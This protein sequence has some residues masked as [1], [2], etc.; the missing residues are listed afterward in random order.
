[1]DTLDRQATAPNLRNQN[2]KSR[3]VFQIKDCA[4]T[5][6]MR[7]LSKLFME[8]D[9]SFFE[10]AEKAVNN[11][12]QN[13]FFESMREIR[14]KKDSIISRFSTEFNA[15]CD[16]FDGQQ[17]G[18]S[19]PEA[20]RSIE[21]LAL[22]QT[23]ELERNVTINNMVNNARIEC[24]EQ[25]Y[26]LNK[27][28]DLLIPSVSV[29]EQ[30]NPLDPAQICSAF[31][32]ASDILD[33]KIKGR[34]V[35]FKQFERMVM[36]D[37]QTL[38]TTANQQLINAGILPQVQ[39]TAYKNQSRS[40]PQQAVPR[41]HEVTTTAPSGKL[42][43]FTQ[44]FAELSQLLSSVRDL[45]ISGQ[46]G[47]PLFVSQNTGP[48]LDSTELSDLLS[49]L[50]QRHPNGD[51][52]VS[53]LQPQLDLR[54]LL[55]EVLNKRQEK[56]QKAKVGKSDEDVINLIA[57][58]FD[59]VLDDKQ[60]PIRIQALVSRLQIPVLKVSLKDR[61]FFSTADHP[62]R[63]LIN[64]I[65]AV[66]IGMSDK[67]SDSKE[68]IFSML[69]DIIH[70]IHDHY[71]TDNTIFDR[72][73]NTL[74]AFRNKAES[75]ASKIT[76]RTSE[77]AE[78]EAKT[79]HAQ[80][81]IKTLILDRLDGIEVPQAVHEFAIQHWQQVLFLARIKHG[82]ESA[83]WIEAVQ[84]LDD[85][86]WTSQKH[87]DDKSKARLTRIL[88]DLQK[89][90][91][92]W[93]STAQPTKDDTE[94]ALFRINELQKALVVKDTEEV[95]KRHSLDDKQRESLQSDIGIEKSWKEM[96]AV[97]R[98]QVQYKALTYDFIKKA[99]DLSL[100]SWVIFTK[101]SDD[102]SMRCKLAAKI[103]AN[104]SFVFVNRMGFKVVEK[105]RK[106]F[107]Y[108][109]QQGR[110]RIVE[111]EMFFDRMMAKVSDRLR[112]H[113]SEPSGHPEPA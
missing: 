59:F 13:M 7:L 80:A 45:A 67:E 50:Q 72:S 27:R 73:L 98:Q 52:R 107:A 87:S 92:H 83:D 102:E 21:S 68:A 15:N 11:N 90:L 58:F 69:S 109:L 91:R 20:R 40:K 43:P 60:L 84:T 55:T 12:E 105:K 35:L 26:H 78:A 101:S 82:I 106:E 17:K 41:H 97:E 30:N 36:Q 6:L 2:S 33:I 38:L 70:D 34:I 16:V 31:A 75:K 32:T 28:L 76:K 24:Q 44:Q 71:E 49:E 9:N 57:M 3:L 104:D 99:D 37:L 53:P 25:L 94:R 54:S 56:G 95:V 108:N 48:A 42:A 14:L 46:L 63:R 5:S 103:D 23:D 100:G 1:M 89:R 22:V 47:F 64:E 51:N 77:T 81:V 110:A 8:C 39:H 79:Q 85:L 86:L 18:A 112:Q 93:L 65:V 29:S 61:T 66:S 62:V 19:R 96:T 88:P 111:H 74:K 4:S 113:T 10:S